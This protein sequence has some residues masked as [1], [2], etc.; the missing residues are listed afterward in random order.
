MENILNYLN[1]YITN[2]VAFLLFLCLGLGFV[3]GKLKI[4]SFSLGATVGTLIVGIILSQIATVEIS[5]TI[6]TVFFSLFC[7][8][9]GFD[10]GPGFFSGLRSSGI[11]LILL[12]VFFTVI[13]VV[14]A[15]LIC[16]IFNLDAGYGVGILGGALTQSSVTGAAQLDS[17][18]G[19]HVTTAFGLT[20]IF[21]T[22][23]VVFFVKNIAPLILRKSLK[24][25][26]KEKVDSLS[27]VVS[28]EPGKYVNHILQVR[29]FILTEDSEYCGYTVEQLEEKFEGRIEIEAVYRGD[30][31][32][33]DA[34]EQSLLIGD[35]IQVIG[36]ISILDAVD[37]KGFAEVSEPKYFQ[38]ELVDAKIV[39][40][41]DFI[42]NGEEILSN[43]GILIKPSS[44]HKAFTSNSI[45]SVRGS[46]KAIKK[47]AKKLG[48][49]K[50]EGDVTD[51]AFLSI[52]TAVGLLVGSLALK[53]N[54]LS[55][56]LG[57][58]VGTLL[59]GLLCGWWYNRKPRIG[60]IPT[61]TRIFLKSLGLNFY[62]AAL[63]LEV[64]EKFF[65]SF[66]ENGLKLILLG[67]VLTLVP[68]LFSLLFGKFVM[69]IDDADLLGGLC[70]CGTCTAALNG[71]SDETNSSVFALGYA[72]GCAAGNI[73]LTI[74]GVVLSMIL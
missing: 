57:D 59:A 54:H 45:I 64:G 24:I 70:G 44:K 11:K 12:S 21:G 35:V 27:T 61:A 14:T 73:F 41:D 15:F 22:L 9:I 72:P 18:L 33:R 74:G 38:V 40:T 26:V 39:L 43:Y 52:A 48:Y 56:S 31:I 53:W 36:D 47:A 46:E 30:D 10:V 37:K 13:S 60:H 49:I 63:S 32:L 7:F 6:K 50:D 17:S 16:R 29:A 68:H 62:I 3:V 58:C 23:G 67:V 51:I 25:I 20:Y 71:L 69:R 4:K 1:D 19:G 65:A 5:P 66:G 42:E 8:T 2:H 55:F 28:H 34:Q